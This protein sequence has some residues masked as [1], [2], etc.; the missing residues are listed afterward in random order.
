[1]AQKTIVQLIDDLDQGTADET[2]S[3]GLDGSSYEIDL[4]TA[5]AAK[6]RDALAVYIAN[7][8]R[9]GRSGGSRPSGSGRRSSGRGARSDREQLQAIRDWGRKNGW[10]VNARG[11]IPADLLDA[12]NSAT[13]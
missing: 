6:L 10:T 7:A 3:F 2:V 5:N 12:Y 1:M 13:P 4:S 9:A 11:R 8:R